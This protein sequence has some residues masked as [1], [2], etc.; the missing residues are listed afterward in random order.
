TAGTPFNILNLV[1]ADRQFNIDGTYSGSR[2]ISYSG[3]GGVP[4][5]TTTASFSGG[6]ST[7]ALTTT[8]YKAETTAI[9]AAAGTVTGVLS[10]SFIVN[11]Q[12]FA[13][14]QLLA[15]G[16]VAAP[17]TATGKTGTPNAQTANNGFNVTVN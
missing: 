6:Q 14:L 11:P 5:Y 9:S 7:T 2:T 3:P 1:A 17:G 13:K 12:A 10:S 4:S 15:P 8:L 16:E